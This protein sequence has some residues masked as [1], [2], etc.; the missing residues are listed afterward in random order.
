[1]ESDAQV[2]LRKNFRR[3][4]RDSNSA[5]EFIARFRG[6]GLAFDM[7]ILAKKGD[8]IA[9]HIQ[10]SLTEHMNS[11][12]LVLRAS[13]GMPNLLVPSST[14][15]AEWQFL[16]IKQRNSGTSPILHVLDR[17]NTQACTVG[18][19]VKYARK[20]PQLPLPYDNAHIV[21]ISKHQRYIY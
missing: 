10:P 5:A 13:N 4:P 15:L 12:N 21:I 11:H 9:P 17:P 7:Q 16:Y 8:L 6:L 18:E 19:M 3:G 1:M 20:M 14:P 2:F